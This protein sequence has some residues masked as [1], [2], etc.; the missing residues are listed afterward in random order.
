MK[1]FVR[2]L[3][4]FS[5]ACLVAAYTKLLFAVTPAELAGLPSDVAI[6][7]LAW[8]ADLGW[9]IALLFALFSL[10]FA[11]IGLSVGELRAKRGWSYYAVVALGVA[12][13]G[14]AAQWAS[15]VQGAP[16]VM[17]QYAL[18]AYA[19]AGVTA[20]F[21]YWL[22]AGR[23]AGGPKTSA[24]PLIIDTTK[25]SPPTKPAA[26]AAPAK[27]PADKPTAASGAGAKG[28]LEAALAAVAARSAAEAQSAAAAAS[29]STA[30]P[31]VKPT[32]SSPATPIT[33]AVAKPE[34]KA[35]SK[36]ELKAPS[37]PVVGPVSPIKPATPAA[38]TA[39]PQQSA[40]PRPGTSVPPTG[41]SKT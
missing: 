30:K 19:T 25:P 41:P 15:E 22:V 24:Y 37:V 29:A 5:V 28:G 35:E 9:K 40:Q 8:L 4:G 21:S 1:R 38:I 31:D 12:L 10:P 23:Y 33:P 18:A 7:R 14:F 32:S 2:V 20:G 6:D 16:S 13:V 36:P 27:S 39:T 34:A 3:I 26:T 17:T 11:L